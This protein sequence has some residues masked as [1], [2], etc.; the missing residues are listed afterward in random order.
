MPN[1]VRGNL[2][3]GPEEGCAQPVRPPARRRMT[4]AARGAPRSVR[5]SGCRPSRRCRA[6]IAA[7]VD[8]TALRP[9]GTLTG[10]LI[11]REIMTR[12]VGGVAAEVGPLAFA[13]MAA[14]ALRAAAAFAILHLSRVVAFRTCR[15]MRMAP[16][17]HILRMPPARSARRPS[18]KVV[19]HRTGDPYR[20]GPLAADGARGFVSSVAV[21]SG[22][23]ILMAVIASALALVATAPRPAALGFISRRGRRIGPAFQEGSERGAAMTDEV[24]DAPGSR[25]PLT[26]PSSMPGWT[27]R[28][29]RPRPAGYM[30]GPA[31]ASRARRPSSPYATHGAVDNPGWPHVPADGGAV[32]AGML[33]RERGAGGAGLAA[34]AARAA[35]A[36]MGLR[37][38]PGLTTAG[39]SGCALA[40]AS[41][42]R[43]LHGSPGTSSPAGRAP[44]RL[45]SAD[46]LEVLAELMVGRGGPGRARSDD[47]PEF[48]AGERAAGGAHGAR[49][50]PR[51]VGER[52][53][54][55]PRRKAPRRAPLGGAPT[56]R[57]GRRSR[58]RPGAGA[59]T[60]RALTRRPDDGR[61]RKRSR[62]PPLG[63]DRPTPTHKPNPLPRAGHRARV[64]SVPGTGRRRWTSSRPR[65]PRSPRP[66][67]PQSPVAN[68]RIQTVRRGGERF[69]PRSA[70]GRNRNS[71]PSLP[72]VVLM[73]PAGGITSRKGQGEV[74]GKLQARDASSPI[75]AE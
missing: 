25:R 7:V 12:V 58:S 17:V 37:P 59:T 18:G 65:T 49:R 64:G 1:K 53:R 56:P 4:A 30:G 19:G 24:Q 57:A 71:S 11:V 36:R 34:A 35:R 41:D 20:F 33:G 31:L 3:R 6:L 29:E 46:G 61:P 40:A 72:G 23:L 70:R 15:D 14:H 43:R 28:H 2:G 10:P 8:L 74:V 52:P 47:G 75:P 32:R 21:T 38:R 27:R 13:V 60:P 45:G 39:R 66:G 67:P 55:G 51:P 26:P 42:R 62:S 73:T 44:R 16:H 48:A 9:D 54:R 63:L 69:D 50:A 22:V 5:S 68:E